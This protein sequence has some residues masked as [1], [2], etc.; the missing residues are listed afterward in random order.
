MV[1]VPLPANTPFDHIPDA[2]DAYLEGYRE[3]YA[4]FPFN[5]PPWVHVGERY[6]P[7]DPKTRGFRDG[8]LEARLDAGKK[9]RKE[10]E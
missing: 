4:R 1:E 6:D 10:E 3:G 2:R 8:A 5:A 9:L 7:T